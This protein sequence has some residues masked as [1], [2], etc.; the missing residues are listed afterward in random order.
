MKS[1]SIQSFSQTGT[2]LVS[3]LLFLIPSNWFLKGWEETAFVRG[4]FVD[5]LV[6]KFYATD[7][8]LLALIVLAGGQIWKNGAPKV[9]DSWRKRLGVGGLILL[10]FVLTQLWISPQVGTVWFLGK[11][12]LMTAGGVALTYLWPRLNQTVVMCAITGT[13]LFQSGLALYQH[14]FQHSLGGYWLLGE[15]TIPNAIGLASAELNG[16]V[17][18]LPY[19]TTAHPNI[20]GGVLALYSLLLLQ[21]LVQIWRTAKLSITQRRSILLGGGVVLALAGWT[22]FLTHSLSALLT[23]GIGLISIGWRWIRPQ[24][25]SSPS[26]RG[27]LAGCIVLILFIAPTIIFGLRDPYADVTSISRRVFLNQA[28]L[29]MIV[30]HPVTGVGANAFTQTLEQYTVTPEVV[31]FVQPAHHVPLLWIAETGLIGVLVIAM[32]AWLWVSWVGGP[33]SKGRQRVLANGLWAVLILTPVLAFDHYLVTLNTGL[34]L[35]VVWMIQ[36]LEPIPN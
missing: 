8:I 11:L 31:R 22:L 34:L 9:S 2:I 16:V 26:Q 19:G 28:A 14:W 36:Q 13:L 7:F 17:Q 32:T 10:G 24:F 4:L 35:G 27:F 29:T 12:V 30:T 21:H 15:P 25:G 33:T 6:P 23:L 5:Y 20:L 18:V 3:L 1:L